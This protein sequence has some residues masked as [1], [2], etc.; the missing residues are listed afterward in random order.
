MSRTVDTSDLSAVQNEVSSVFSSLF[1]QGDP[2]FIGRI[3]GWYELLFHGKYPGYQAL[4]AGYHDFEHTLQGTLCL[5]RLLQGRHFAGVEPLLTPQI[6]E[7]GLV[8]I[9][10]HDTG[11]LKRSDDLNGTG[12]KYTLTHVQRSIAF[13]QVFL[14]E[15]GLSAQN[16]LAVQNM[17]RCTGV[18]MDLAAI[19][20]TSECEKMVGFSLGTS[21]LLGQMAAA[22]YVDK[23][24]ALYLEF[25]EASEFKEGDSTPPVLF[26]SAD[27]L[28]R[29]TQGFWNGYV[30]PKINQ[31]FGALYRFLAHPY[32]DGSNAYLDAIEMNLARLSRLTATEK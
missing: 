27:D 2:N 7:L 24:P 21:D 17:I 22:D 13:S 12:A 3:F 16:I 31:D 9:L 19:P 29:K 1:P 11:Y 14:S 5:A 23:L 8:A 30:W 25:K 15:K 26:Q 32:P 10:L 4:D 6:F 28:M 20:F 18:N